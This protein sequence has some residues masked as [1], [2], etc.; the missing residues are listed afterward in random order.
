MRGSGAQRPFRPAGIQKNADEGFWVRSP[1]ADHLDL[2][3]PARAGA[4]TQAIAPSALVIAVVSGILIA[5][6]LLRP[7][8][9]VDAAARA[10]LETAIAAFAILTA[11]FL[12][13]SF[14]RSRQLRE[15]LLLVGVL[16]LAVA[17]VG[18]WAGSALAA[19]RSLESDGPVRLGCEMIGAL[20]FAAA[21]LMPP[22]VIAER[23]RGVA[24]VIVV[25]G[26][27]VAVVGTVLAQVVAAHGD[28]AHGDASAA[29]AGTASTAGH[30]VVIGI[31]VASAAILAVAALAFVAG[32]W[33]AESGSL[34]L[35]GASLLLAAAGLQFLAIPTI[36][37]DWVTPRD[38]VSLAAYAFLLGS[39]YLGYARLRRRE[40]DTAIRAERERIARDLH[41]GMAQDLACIA[42]QAQR[43]DCRLGPEHPLVLAN[44]NALAELRGMITDL[45]ASTAPT[46][47][48]A[49]RLIAHELGQRFGVQVNVRIEADLALSLDN[50]LE[51]AQRDDLIRVAR[52]AI[53][54]AAAHGSARHIDVALLGRAGTLVVRVS[55]DGHRIPNGRPAGRWL[56]S[57]R[58]RGVSRL[59]AE[60]PPPARQ[61]HRA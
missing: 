57:K 44:R 27:G 32:S 39:A 52:E 60:P 45:T 29:N 2:G 3:M 58:A 37:S 42:A 41:D 61:R 25:L 47:E 12:M 50:R 59:S 53:V 6:E 10:A 20:A 40:A 55:G 1:G 24:K 43:L 7:V 31:H 26:F 14:D 33:R 15:L 8:H 28:A 17:D 35:A 11:R 4:W 22:T 19:A 30:P 18:A 5:L 16:A 36:A 46:C 9:G 38:G 51:L 56:R 48:V 54:N 13:E 23:R 49:L 21:A 34:L